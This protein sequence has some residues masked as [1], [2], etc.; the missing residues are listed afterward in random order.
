M[1]FFALYVNKQKIFI[2][3]DGNK[4][5]LFDLWSVRF[6]SRWLNLYGFELFSPHDSPTT[7]EFTTATPAL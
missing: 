1:L 2:L 6:A 3:K 7:S 5:R 4:A